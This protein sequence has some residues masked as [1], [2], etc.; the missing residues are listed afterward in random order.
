MGGDLREF[1]VNLASSPELMAEFA[2]DP[3]GV[4]ARAGLSADDTAAVLAR[5]SNRLR[6]ALGA[7]AADHLTHVTIVTERT[8]RKRPARKKP[9]AKKRP[10]KKRPS[11]KRPSKKRPSKKGR[12]GTKK[13]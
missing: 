9:A 1:L 7:S 8:L 4:L 3:A 2:A 10:S 6:L 12:T 13:R 11:K 5:D